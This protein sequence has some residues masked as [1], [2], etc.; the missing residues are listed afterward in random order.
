MDIYGNIETNLK[1]FGIILE[2]NKM[3]WITPSK[4]VNKPIDDIV[5]STWINL[6][7][8][9]ELEKIYGKSGNTASQDIG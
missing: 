6:Y 5:D 2:S 4:V 8:K 9:E 1:E 3:E 7:L